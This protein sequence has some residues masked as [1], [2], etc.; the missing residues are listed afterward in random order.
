ME[1]LVCISQKA[2]AALLYSLNCAIHQAEYYKN[3]QTIP[4][5]GEAFQ[6]YIDTV[7]QHLEERININKDGFTSGHFEVDQL[8]E[9]NFAIFKNIEIRVKEEIDF[10]QRQH[11]Y[12]SHFQHLQKLAIRGLL[13]KTIKLTLPSNLYAIFT[14]EAPF[15]AQKVTKIYNK[16]IKPPHWPP[17]FNK[18]SRKIEI[19]LDNFPGTNPC[20]SKPWPTA[21]HFQYFI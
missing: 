7:K 19:T 20:Y 2:I 13:P 12:K 10:P 4:N 14:E 18:T 5:L 21:Q 8:P 1:S 16:V 15:L 3:N 6:I 17:S 9:Y 11:V